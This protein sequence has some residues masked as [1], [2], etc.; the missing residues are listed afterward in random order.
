M[1]RTAEGPA[2]PVNGQV[3]PREGASEPPAR[4]LVALGFLQECW[5]RRALAA[6]PE[7]LLLLRFRLPGT[8][9]LQPGDQDGRSGLSWR[10]GL[11]FLLQ[12]FQLR[13]P[14][15]GQAGPWRQGII[16]ISTSHRMTVI[17]ETATKFWHSVRTL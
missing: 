13:L 9:G 14:C 16:P 11:C 4:R 12:G 7:H 15:K 2:P 3:W 10:C 1:K 8:P 17:S 5:W 6:C